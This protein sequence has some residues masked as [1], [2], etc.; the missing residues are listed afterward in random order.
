MTEF[1]AQEDV[2]EETE[3]SE[4]EVVE[5]QEESEPDYKTQLAEMSGRVDVLTNYISKNPQ[6]E[7]AEPVQEEFSLEA[8]PENLEELSREQFADLMLQRT[9]AQI[10]AKVVVPLTQ[11]ISNLGKTLHQDSAQSQI[12]KAQAAHSDFNEWGNEMADLISSG[13][14]SGKNL[15]DAYT[16]ARA[17]NPAKAQKFNTTEKQ[18][19]SAEKQETQPKANSPMRPGQVSPVGTTNMDISEAANAAWNKVGSDIDAALRN[20]ETG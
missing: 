11:E 1:M 13:R 6:Q 12:E 5:Q 9:T 15:L 10:Q 2:F 3:V 19:V 14:V 4:E 18:K 16:I 8:L 7:K 17:E 20:M